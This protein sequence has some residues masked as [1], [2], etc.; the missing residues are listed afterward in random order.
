VQE[1]DLPSQAQVSWSVVVA[2][3][4]SQYLPYHSPRL[5]LL[6]MHTLVP[7]LVVSSAVVL[8]SSQVLV[9]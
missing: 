4:Q 7:P 9:S 3:A 6:P 1:Q 8:V 5:P 2:E